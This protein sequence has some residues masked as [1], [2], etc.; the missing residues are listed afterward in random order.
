MSQAAPSGDRLN[1]GGAPSTGA[2]QWGASPLWEYRLG[3]IVSKTTTGP[4][5][6]RVID[7]RVVPYPNRTRRSAG[8]LPQPKRAN[9]P[10]HW[11]RQ[12]S[13]R[14]GNTARDRAATRFGRRGASRG[15]HQISAVD[16]HQPEPVHQAVGSGGVARRSD[17]TELRDWVSSAAASDL[18][19]SA[20]RAPMQG[21]NAAR[22]TTVAA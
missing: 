20:S 21:M 7:G 13:A 12:P 22:M 3:L 18:D 2:M 10:P 17:L 6:M 16:S 8:W 9:K 11:H 15:A 4:W 1:E 14:R 19:A 5:A